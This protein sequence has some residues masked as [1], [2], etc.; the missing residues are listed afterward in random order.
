MSKEIPQATV[1]NVTNAALSPYIRKL[2]SL[3]KPMDVPGLNLI[4]KGRDFDGGYTM[5]DYKLENKICYS[6]GISD[7]V[8][9]DI[10]MASIGCQVF[11]YDH[12]IK[13]F[14]LKHPSFHSFGVGICSQP[15]NE[16]NLKTIEE[17]IEI[18]QHQKEDSIIMKMDIEGAEWPVFYDIKENIILKFSQI[19][20]EF[21]G[22]EHSHSTRHL[23][24][25][26]NVLEKINKTHQI[27]HIHANNYGSMS[28]I[29]GFPVPD[30]YEISLV[31]RRDH[32]FI[33]SKKVYPTA[34]DMP[35]DAA[36]PDYFLGAMGL[37]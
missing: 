10:D 32:Q 2:L 17:L 9:W 22:L 36:R 1:H 34:I 27:I 23:R 12:T 13:S 33:E 4:R 5:L 15:T 6:M 3:L 26:L 25:Y 7:D 29:S 14:P 37:Y 8:S 31:R 28:L 18:N 21:H 30:T 16:P 35:C 19:I 20:V 11:Q 24:R